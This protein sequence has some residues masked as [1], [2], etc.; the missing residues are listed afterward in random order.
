LEGIALCGISKLRRLRVANCRRSVTARCRARGHASSIRQPRT[1]PRREFNIRVSQQQLNRTQ[2]GAGL[3]CDDGNMKGHHA[4]IGVSTGWRSYVQVSR[5]STRARPASRP[6]RA[7][8]EIERNQRGNPASGTTTTWKSTRSGS[9]LWLSPAL[10]FL[11]RSPSMIRKSSRSSFSA[12]TAFDLLLWTTALSTI[13]PPNHSR[14]SAFRRFQP[15][16]Q[17]RYE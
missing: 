17:R 13:S 7:A 5:C 8:M 6:D 1:A 2:V 16:R 12:V 3:D 10:R 9:P 15:D 11:L 4:K 14:C